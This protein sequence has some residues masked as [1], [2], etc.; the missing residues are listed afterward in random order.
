MTTGSPRD[1]QG[2]LYPRSQLERVEEDDSVSDQ[3]RSQGIVSS[4]QWKSAVESA[5][6]KTP[7]TPIRPTPYEL[8]SVDEGSNEQE[9][10]SQSEDDEADEEVAD[11]HQAL[12]DDGTPRNEEEVEEDNIDDVVSPSRPILNHT[13]SNNNNKTNTVH[14]EEESS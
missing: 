13:K 6:P 7:L 3:E 1:R 11:E 2:V 8:S 14:V 12:L 5:E 4:S 10:P 9:S